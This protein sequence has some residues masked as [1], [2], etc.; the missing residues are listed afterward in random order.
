M[1]YSIILNQSSYSKMAS[2][3]LLITKAKDQ[4]KNFTAS[5]KQLTALNKIF[6]IVR[7]FKP[8]ISSLLR[9]FKSEN[10]YKLSQMT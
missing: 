5:V 9:T 4:L 1:Q 3:Y 10:F 6:F 2:L 7:P 8:K